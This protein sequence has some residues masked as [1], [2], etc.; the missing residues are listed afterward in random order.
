LAGLLA[1][2]RTDVSHPGT[3]GPSTLER[4]WLGEALIWVLRVRLLAELGVPVSR[5][6][7]R[8]TTKSAFQD[9]LSELA[10]LQ[11]SEAKP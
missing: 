3:E 9:A 5:L 4:Y 1:A 2:A 7:A 6:S 11:P 8:I 10:R